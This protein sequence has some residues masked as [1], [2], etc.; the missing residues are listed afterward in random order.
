M[1]QIAR[2]V[3][4]TGVLAGQSLVLRGTYPFVRGELTLTGDEQDV[5]C[6]VRNLE[7]NFCAYLKGDP[8]LNPTPQPEVEDGQRDLQQV[9]DEPEGEPPVHG[10]VQPEGGGT[11]TGDDAV[12]GSGPAGAEA[13]HAGSLPDGDGQQA[14][15]NVSDTS[16]LPPD[17]DAVAE[18]NEKLK[19][20]VL[21]LSQDEPTHWTAEGK[22]AIAAV[23]KLYG[24]TGITRADVE[25]AAPG[26]RRTESAT[27]ES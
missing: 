13:G 6:E 24:S 8:R 21:G 16:R 11:S 7:R 1:P 4:L 27:K 12:V 23:S 10:E 17:G 20:A 9:G 15:L 25:A 2:T 22:P 18:V 26:F 14:Q 3:V 5:N 19:R